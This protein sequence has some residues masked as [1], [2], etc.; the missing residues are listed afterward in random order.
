MSFNQVNYSSKNIDKTAEMISQMVISGELK[1][2]GTKGNVTDIVKKVMA[3]NLRNEG[4]INRNGSHQ[5]QSKENLTALASEYIVENN[6]YLSL[7]WG[8]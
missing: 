4:I 6:F 2:D 3:S 7:V 1:S 8:K 5:I